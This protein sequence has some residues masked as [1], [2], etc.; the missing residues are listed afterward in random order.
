[1][2][3]DEDVFVAVVV[4]V[5]GAVAVGTLFG[6]YDSLGE[7]APCRCFHST[8]LHRSILA[9]GHRIEVAIVV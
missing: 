4:H 8:R 5:D 1:M 3:S 7:F 6:H 9:G 2:T